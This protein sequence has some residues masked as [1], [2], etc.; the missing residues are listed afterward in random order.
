MKQSVHYFTGRKDQHNLFIVDFCNLLPKD[1][2]A[3]N[4]SPEGM[5]Q[6]Y[7]E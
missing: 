6:D 7:L 1:K 4:V 3:E 2:A 5:D